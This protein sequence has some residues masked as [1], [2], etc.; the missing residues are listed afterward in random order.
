MD[1]RRPCNRSQSGEDSTIGLIAEEV[2]KVNP[3]LAVRDEAGKVMTV[4]YDA[5]NAMV[6]NEFLRSIVRT[7]SRRKQ[8]TT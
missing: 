3:D 2:E 6:F 4:R 8:S 1:P 5:V 7:R